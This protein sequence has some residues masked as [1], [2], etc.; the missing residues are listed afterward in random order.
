[1]ALAYHKP[2][3]LVNT[4]L[5]FGMKKPLHVIVAC[6]TYGTML[7]QKFGAAYITTEAA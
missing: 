6:S 5:Y 3:T 4:F 1:M 7:L 2:S